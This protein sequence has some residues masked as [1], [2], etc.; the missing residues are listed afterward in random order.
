M[1]KMGVSEA[2][3]HTRCLQM[4]KEALGYFNFVC[5]LRCRTTHELGKTLR[6]HSR[7]RRVMGAIVVLTRFARHVQSRPLLNSNDPITMEPLDGVNPGDLFI[8]RRG[9]ARYGCEPVAFAEYIVKTGRVMDPFTNTELTE[10]ELRRLDQ[11]TGF[12]YLLHLQCKSGQLEKRRKDEL[13]KRDAEV[14]LE[15][16]VEDVAELCAEALQNVLRGG[17]VNVFVYLVCEICSLLRQAEDPETKT[18]LSSRLM[19]RLGNV[20]Q[21]EGDLTGAGFSCVR[22]ADTCLANACN[23]SVGLFVA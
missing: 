6:F 1:Y 7:A 12:V 8:Y 21:V 17:N 22:Y 20:V 4:T 15:I 16:C 10:A 3:L 14:A 23:A 2:D 18:R 9:A 5:G 13:R 19:H 11:K